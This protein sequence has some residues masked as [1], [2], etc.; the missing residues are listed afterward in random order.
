MVRFTRPT[1]A[2]SDLLEL[3]YIS[4]LHQTQA[5]PVRASGSIC[6]VDVALFLRSRFGVEVSV[7][8]VRRTVLVGLGGEDDE[9]GVID[10]AELAAVLLIP[11][12][13][14]A[15]KA[16]DNATAD[17]DEEST[18]GGESQ[19][20]TLLYPEPGL[21]QTVLT[22][23]LRDVTGSSDPPPI[24]AALLK[25]I[26]KAYGEEEMAS[27]EALMSEMVE[28]ATGGDES[29]GTLDLE[30][31]SRALTSDIS[32]YDVESEARL[33][34]NYHD[35]M[36]AAPV[37]IAARNGNDEEIFVDEMKKKYVSEGDGDEYENRDS[38]DQFVDE[39][40]RKD[41]DEHSNVKTRKFFS[42]PAIDMTSCRY[43]SKLIVVLLWAGFVIS[44]FA[45]FGPFIDK[46]L[47][48]SIIF[49]DCDRDEEI[50]FENLGCNVG[51]SC[52]QWIF[53][54]LTLA[55]FG[56]GYVGFGSIGNSIE[57][58]NAWYRIIAIVVVGFF[59]YFFFFVVYSSSNEVVGTVTTFSEE[60]E[61]GYT[62]EIIAPKSKSYENAVIY[63]SLMVG[64]A[65]LFIHLFLLVG[66]IV[67]RRENQ[68]LGII[69]FFTSGGV[70]AEAR[71]KR[72]AAYKMN[73]LIRNALQIHD[74]SLYNSNNKG[75]DDT[76]DET[77]FGS[78]LVNFSVRGSGELEDVGGFVWTW[79]KIFN[80]TLFSQD[81]VW[82]SGRVLAANF[83]Q[84][85]ITAFILTFG[86][87]LTQTVVDEWENTVNDPLQFLDNLLDFLNVNLQVDIIDTA[88]SF[89]D[90]L[91]GGD[92]T[93]LP[94]N[95]TVPDTVSCGAITKAAIKNALSS[96]VDSL[97]PVEKYMVQVPMAITTMV[98]FFC[99]LAL[100]IIY[101]PSVASTTLQLRSGAIPFFRDDK[102]FKEYRSQMDQ[103]TILLGSMFW[104]AL[105]ASAFCG[106]LIGTLL[107]LLLWQAT[108]QVFI[109]L[110]A[111]LIG[112]TFTLGVKAIIGVFF[113]RSSYVAFYRKKVNQANIVGLIQECIMVG[114]AV[115]TALGRAAKLVLISA[116]YVGRMD[117][118]LLAP[119]VGMGPLA[120][121]YPMIFRKDILAQEAH[122]H[123]YL[124]VIGKI[125]LM[126]LR[127]GKAFVSRA[128]YC[129]RL[130]FTVALM[131]WLRKYRVM[132]RPNLSLDNKGIDSDDTDGA[133]DA[134]MSTGVRVGIL[135]KTS[136]LFEGTHKMWKNE[137]S[138]GGVKIGTRCG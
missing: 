123:P 3:E 6:D 62:E 111:Y 93:N 96:G 133:N 14:K 68:S 84:L 70:K 103:V 116:L 35:V 121:N 81:G 59:T 26:F 23:I 41:V 80:G 107:F 129:Y 33:T 104:G 38:S 58:V 19:Q 25:N 134:I 114:F 55:V 4:A 112:L 40:K 119:G 69:S 88:V 102:N 49:G 89:C 79:K 113:L 73:R 137:I 76:N 63:V 34:T 127:H 131:P 43:D 71:I 109:S 82:L 39:T 77:S 118:P 125:Y 128:G 64:S 67:I 124:G 126:K 105:Y 92:L 16:G 12:I 65:V 78:A 72:A 101:I 31:F 117:T 106:I 83:A 20:Y 136:I 17:N 32:L 100:V 132:A 120:D 1:G 9:E 66:S 7:E 61:D 5:G 138:T 74:S 98:A 29:T 85:S 36:V 94:I 97:F 45:Y 87:S 50:G 22:M 24:T 135:S 47:P 28:V 15:V 53:T 10:L 57:A 13:L 46:S 95:I 52:V 108:T 91:V 110:L 27:N 8:D 122:R 18:A 44:Y 115:G 86:I 42:S 60:Y 11:A 130:I 30:A 75:R 21:L 2:E 51:K 56:L 37:T 99:C 48:T 54:L 90:A